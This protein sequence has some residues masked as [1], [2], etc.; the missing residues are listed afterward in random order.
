MP[1][2]V[3]P[4]G[5][6]YGVLSGSDGYH[7][8]H[9]GSQTGSWDSSKPGDVLIE[10][11]GLALQTTITA[12]QSWSRGERRNEYFEKTGQIGP[13]QPKSRQV[14]D[15][16]GAGDTVISTLALALSAKPHFLKPRY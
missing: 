3:D 6:A 9:L 15:V 7:P 5:R 12:R 4:E 10:H 8:N 13:S 2:V 14:Y 16:T 11:I 1:V